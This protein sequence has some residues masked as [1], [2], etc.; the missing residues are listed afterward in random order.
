MSTSF[1]YLGSGLGLRAPHYDTI[2]ADR[3]K[4]VE[5]FEII[6]ENFIE[7]HKGYKEFLADLRQNYPIVMH[8]VSL[9][10]GGT[11]PLN[12]D[13]LKKLKT[14]AQLIEAPWISDHLCFT[15]AGGH[16]THDLLPIPYNEESLA[17]LVS[18]IHAVQEALARPL[19]LE[20]PSSYVEFKNSTITEWDFLAALCER[21]G[22]KLL[23]DVNNAYVSAYNHGF[24]AKTYID[25]IPRE[26]IVQIHLAGH[27]NHG[28]YI[29]DTH[30]TPVIDEV[31]QL[32]AYTIAQKGK[33][34]TMVEWDESI[35]AFDVVLAELAK[36]RACTANIKEAA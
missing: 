36:A 25:A 11:D 5:W 7:A 27:S 4:D 29:I 28:D 30:D 3:P 9:S 23:F 6:S 15:G 13:Y 17:H 34:S 2:L 18:R 12:Q 16:N 19:V 8:G 35:P 32:Y 22:C 26:S 1:P 33:I 10:I 24:D 31:W 14:L 21:T 20:N